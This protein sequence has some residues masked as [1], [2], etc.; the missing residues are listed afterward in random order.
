MIVFGPRA[1]DCDPLVYLGVNQE[2]FKG[3]RLIVFWGPFLVPF[4]V[5]S[6][7]SSLVFFLV[8]VRVS[9]LVSFLVRPIKRSTDPAIGR[10]I[11]R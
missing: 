9:F 1:P 7:V 8:C 2:I 5:S 3:F 10:A 4:L 11:E 6:L